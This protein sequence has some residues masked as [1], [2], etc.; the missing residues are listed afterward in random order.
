MAKSTSTGRGT[1][2]YDAMDKKDR[3]GRFLLLGLI[4][5]SGLHVGIV[6]LAMFFSYSKL[7][8]AITFE[9]FQDLLIA[10]TKVEVEEPPE[11]EESAS[12]KAG[13]EEGKFGEPDSPSEE[14]KL[15]DHDG[16]MV[17]HIDTSEL[18]KA[19]DSALAQN[20][21]LQA[22]FQN[23]DLAGAMGQ[24]FAT[25]GEGD[26][27]VVGRGNGGLGFGGNGRGGGGDGFGRVHG[28]GKIDTGGGT[29]VGSGLGRRAA[30]GPKARVTKGS[31]TING[32]LSREQIE[33]VV[34][35]RS[36]AIQYCYERELQ[37]DATLA[38]RIGA[39]WTI[40]LDGKVVTASITENTMGNRNVESCIL[41]VVQGMR[42]DKP[43]GGMVVVAY[44]FTFRAAE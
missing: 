19:F 2:G 10:E 29:G 20:S 27:M 32:F 13:G 28:Q 41:G 44:P 9:A 11:E 38:G 31:P 37:N 30:V 22:I 40:G 35:L 14:T 8:R 1:T 6:A 43:D 39:N 36:R 23:N 25:A 34:R 3:N 17:D 7:T 15:P 24:D 16:P 12:K 18:G 33:K 4:G 42:F 21:N 5:G 26:G